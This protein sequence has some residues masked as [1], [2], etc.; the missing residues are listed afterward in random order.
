[1]KRLSEIPVPGFDKPAK[2]P[3]APKAPVTPASP[4]AAKPA[5][6]EDAKT[7][8]KKLLAIIEAMSKTSLEGV[9]PALQQEIKAAEAFIGEDT[10]AYGKDMA[11]FE[12]S[13][14]GKALKWL[15]GRK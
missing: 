12:N 5:E 14:F 15:S 10:S 2:A 1:M 11:W 13:A 8:I 3:A 4:P 9:P 7:H 6:P